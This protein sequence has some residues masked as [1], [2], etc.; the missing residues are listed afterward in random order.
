MIVYV[1]RPKNVLKFAK[2]FVLEFHYFLLGPL[3][4]SFTIAIMKIANSK[5]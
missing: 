4:V 3:P 2:N 5:K 1:L